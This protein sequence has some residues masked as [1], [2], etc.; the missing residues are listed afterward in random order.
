[1]DGDRCPPGL[2]KVSGV[3]D[4]GRLFPIELDVRLAI[5]GAEVPD[6]NHPEYLGD[7]EGEFE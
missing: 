3:S 7:E 6:D 2:G 4:E 1:M 5:G